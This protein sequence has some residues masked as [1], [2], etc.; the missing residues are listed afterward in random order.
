[1]VQR[2]RMTRKYGFHIIRADELDADQNMPF[3]ALDQLAGI[4]PVR[5]EVPLFRRF[6]RSGYTCRR[7]CAGPDSRSQG[8]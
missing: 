5:I 6:S 4:E 8:A 7:L 2:S 3:L 1:L